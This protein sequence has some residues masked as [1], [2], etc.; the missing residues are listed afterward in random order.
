MLRT[1]TLAVFFIFL[2][3]N[4]VCGQQ[5]QV[6][7]EEKPLLKFDRTLDSQLEFRLDTTLVNPA[8]FDDPC[9]D[10]VTSFRFNSV[11]G[12]LNGTNGF[13]DLAKAQRFDF[14]VTPT[15]SV[16]GALVYFA[17]VIVVGD[18]G[19]TVSVWDAD[20]TGAPNNFLGFS[21]SLKVSELVP[22]LS[23]TIQPTVFEFP[24]PVEVTTPQHFIS[25]DLSSAYLTEDTLGILSTSLDC[26]EGISTWELLFTDTLGNVD[27]FS[28]DGS[29]L[30]EETNIDL[31][32]SS[33]IV[34]DLASDLDPFIQNEGLTLF[35]AMP[36][37]TTEE[38][39]FKYALEKNQKIMLEIYHADGRIAQRENM[40]IRSFGE[41][42]E[43]VNVSHLPPGTYYYS[44]IT[45]KARLASR[46][47]IQR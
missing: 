40:G 11:W 20:Q 2:L 18:G 43:S 7:A 32:M 14:N 8:S 27:W 15:Y 45:E 9:S 5:R 41:H 19:I 33:I 37:P 21:D 22:N 46:F 35:P 31:I 6:I 16:I 36:N 34:F 47:I 17:D 44:I 12:F 24:E 3:S 29:G 1:I 4:V 28:Y 42:L 23:G 39:V 38:I 10:E 13:L 26:G 30:T 25:V